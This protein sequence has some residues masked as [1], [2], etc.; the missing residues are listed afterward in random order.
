KLALK[1]EAPLLQVSHR[2]LRRHRVEADAARRG[3]RRKQIRPHERRTR[4]IVRQRVAQHERIVEAPEQYIVVP[5]LLLVKD[6][7]A[8]AHRAARAAPRPPRKSETRREIIFLRRNQARRGKRLA[9]RDQPKARNEII[10]KSRINQPPA[11]KRW[12]ENR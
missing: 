3:A 6:S 2:H 9:R 4:H 12:I 1:I 8:P 7:V 5:V 10:R 11:R